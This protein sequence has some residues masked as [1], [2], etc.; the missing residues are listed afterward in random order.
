MDRQ[1]SVGHAIPHAIRAGPRSADATQC[2]MLQ[3]TFVINTGSIFRFKRPSSC[4]V[5]AGAV[6]RYLVPTVGRGRFSGARHSR[7]CPNLALRF[8][9]AA[10]GATGAISDTVAWFFEISARLTGRSF[11]PSIIPG[12]TNQQL[13]GFHWPNPAETGKDPVAPCARHC[14]LALSRRGGL[15]HVRAA[16]CVRARA[17]DHVRPRLPIPRLYTLRQPTT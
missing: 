10:Y 8:R 5:F 1:S 16:T 11:A 14:H 7:A 4:G 6:C 12:H 9:E 15:R 13:R 17:P 2:V 3:S